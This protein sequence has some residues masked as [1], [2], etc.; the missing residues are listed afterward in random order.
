MAA[1]QEFLRNVE[2]QKEGFS[3]GLQFGGGVPSLFSQSAREGIGFGSNNLTVITT[4][5]WVDNTKYLVYDDFTGADGTDFDA[6]K[7]TVSGAGTSKINTNRGLVK[8][9]TGVG[10]VADTELATSNALLSGTSVYFEILSGCNTK[11]YPAGGSNC[12]LS[13]GINGVTYWTM[14]YSGG[15]GGNVKVIDTTCSIRAEYTGANYDIY[16][17]GFYT[18]TITSVPAL[19][20]F[21][22]SVVN[23]FVG[24]AET[25]G[26]CF[27]DNVRLRV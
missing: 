25:S 12:T 20:I 11:F 8:G 3:F 5:W 14:S 17:N 18:A 2:G 10:L 27:I 6:A 1:V 7:W 4:G 19:T 13:A 24:D 26:E 22:Q 16:V 21:A 15:G 23:H 9:S